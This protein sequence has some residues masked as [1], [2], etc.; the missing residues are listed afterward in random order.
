MCFRSLV[1]TALCISSK[2]FQTSWLHLIDL[3][4]KVLNG[5][6]KKRQ[7]LSLP[8][9]LSPAGHKFHSG[10]SCHS[11][12]PPLL[13]TCSRVHLPDLL[14]FLPLLLDLRS[15]PKIHINIII[16]KTISQFTYT[17][18]IHTHNENNQIYF[19]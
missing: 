14:H 1:L 15:L 7:C 10:I 19:S 3:L 4:A 13:H 6:P 18:P 5:Q 9:L 12:K 2:L 16:K 11:Q 8:L 17:S